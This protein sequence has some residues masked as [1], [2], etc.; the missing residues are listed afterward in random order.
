[1]VDISIPAVGAIAVWTR[2]SD[3]AVAANAWL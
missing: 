1:M 2:C 3:I